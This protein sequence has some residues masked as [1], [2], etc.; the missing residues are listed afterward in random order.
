MLF[1]PLGGYDALRIQK[2]SPPFIALHLFRQSVLKAV[3]LNGQLCG[4][5]I[6]IEIVV[7]SLVLAAK[8]EPCKPSGFQCV[9]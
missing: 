8:F 4:R 1:V 2:L 6:E 5:T 3:E 9:P 7:T